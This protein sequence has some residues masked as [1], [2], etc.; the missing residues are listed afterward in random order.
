MYVNTGMRW[1]EGVVTAV[2]ATSVDVKVLGGSTMRGV[3]DAKS[4]V[5]CVS[6]M[7]FLERAD[8]DGYD[9]RPVRRVTRREPLVQ[10]SQQKVMNE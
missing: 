3:A 1:R 6:S 8:G 5:Q 4:H 10:A 7:T 2:K 9:H